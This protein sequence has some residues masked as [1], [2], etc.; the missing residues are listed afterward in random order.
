MENSPID[1]NSRSQKYQNWFV[2]AI[3]VPFVLLALASIIFSY[4]SSFHHVSVV[5]CTGSEIHGLLVIRK[6][7]EN[8][9][10]PFHVGPKSLS[11]VI[12]GKGGRG[13]DLPFFTEKV[14][15]T[16]EVFYTVGKDSTEVKR[17]KLTAGEM[18]GKNW[19]VLL[20]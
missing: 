1:K 15:K 19:G 3:S 10:Y 6:N 4:F 7:G 20:E 13:F 14:N 8:I 18:N 9:G 2:I 16:F 5:N 17:I 11:V 12:E